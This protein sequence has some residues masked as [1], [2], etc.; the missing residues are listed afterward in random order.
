MLS[1]KTETALRESAAGLLE[2]MRK[3]DR[4]QRL[5]LRDLAHTLQTGREAMDERL[6]FV[7]RSCDEVEARL[8][9][10]LTAESTENVF[11][12][13]AGKNQELLSVFSSD[14]QLQ[15]V[16]TSWAREGNYAKLLELWV[17]GGKP[18]PRL[19]AFYIVGVARIE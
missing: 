14:D 16:V 11:R 2:F 19:S 1:A 12:G 8:A 18:L 13:R 9:G 17:E 15:A 6:A 4:A 7:A 3:P 5:A 10:F